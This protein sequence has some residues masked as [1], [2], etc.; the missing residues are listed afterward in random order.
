MSDSI[1]IIGGG[2]AAARLVRAYREAGGD[3]SLT[4]LSAETQLPYNRPPLSKGFL[5]GTIAIEDVFAEPATA[6]REL[7]VDVRLGASVKAV[8]T[9]ARLVVTAAGTTLGYDRLVLA[10]GSLP[11]RLDIPGEG[12]ER[13]P[14]LSDTRR[15]ARGAGGRDHRR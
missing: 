12:L 3:A 8:D 2:V 4:M 10:S 13:R 9:K 14:H 15:R 5:R 11:R 6:Y 7:D 1:V